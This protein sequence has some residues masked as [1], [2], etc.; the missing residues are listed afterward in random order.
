MKRFPIDSLVAGI[1]LTVLLS[2]VL[3][4][5]IALFAGFIAVIALLIYGDRRN[6]KREGII[7]IRRTQRG[8]NF[9]D[10][11]AKSHKWFWRKLSVVGIVVAIILMFVGSLVLITQAHAV[12]EGA[13]DGGV[14]LLLPG[15]VAAPVN[16]PGVFVVPWWIWVI[17]IAVVI[18]PHEFMHGIMCRI[19]GVRIK[20]VGW[21]LL[22]IIPG[23]FVEPDEAQL[24]KKSRMTKLRVYAAGSFANMIVAAIVLVIALVVTLAIF[25]SGVAVPYGVN[26]AGTLNGTPAYA[27]N[28]TGSI[29]LLNGIEIRN[30]TSLSNALEKYKAGDTVEVVTADTYFISGILPS[31]IVDKIKLHQYNL[32]LASHPEK[33]GAFL[34][35]AGVS[36]SIVLNMNMN[37]YATVS[38]LLLWIFLFSF[39]I[40]LVNLLPI[41]PLDGGLILEELVGGRKRVVKVIS[42]AMLLLLLFNLIGPL[43]LV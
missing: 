17:G 10:H 2:F 8:R 14:K 23:A 27:A 32:T 7:V 40:G 13:K 12:I 6:V 31:G 5:D 33:T 26:F 42:V 21:L 29:I 37:A 15:P 35:I 1:I 16:A 38:V 9:I 4:A 43:F 18:V 36:Q 41:K 30:Q 28:M 25:S 39:G 20:S 11:V 3:S 24:K 34:G 22:I 19:D